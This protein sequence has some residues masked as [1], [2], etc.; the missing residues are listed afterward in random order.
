MAHLPALTAFNGESRNK[1]TKRKLFEEDF[2]LADYEDAPIEAVLP[3]ESKNGFQLNFLD[4]PTVT[5]IKNTF[6]ELIDLAHDKQAEIN[7]LNRRTFYTI[8]LKNAIRPVSVFDLNARLSAL[9][10]CISSVEFT[11]GD[12]CGGQL[13]V[14]F[15]KKDRFSALSQLEGSAKRERTGPLFRSEPLAYADGAKRVKVNKAGAY[16]VSDSGGFGVMKQDSSADVLERVKRMA[17]H[18]DFFQIIFD[19]T[20]DDVKEKT[21]LSVFDIAILKRIV[22]Y[23]VTCCGK[24]TPSGLKWFYTWVNNDKEYPK[25]HVIRFSGFERLNLDQLRGFHDLFPHHVVDVALSVREGQ[26]SVFCN[27]YLSPALKPWASTLFYQPAV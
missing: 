18:D 9:P 8:N 26:I 2:E 15:A 14:D 24:D 17:G 25:L 20:V 4:L 22:E 3:A 6:G 1:S 23:G 27:P 11:A 13:S 7:V 16:K 19:H 5:A 21:E 10:L 12:D